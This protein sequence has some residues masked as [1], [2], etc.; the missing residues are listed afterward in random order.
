MIPSFSS[1]KP[2][3]GHTLAAAGAVEA[4]LSIIAIQENKVF[5]NLGFQNQIPE[6]GLY[7]VTQLENKESHTIFFGCI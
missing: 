5:A 7:P 1:T 6:T 2:F 4:I 3:T